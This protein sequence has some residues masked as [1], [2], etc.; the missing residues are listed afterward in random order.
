[1]EKKVETSNEEEDDDDEESD[2][3]VTENVSGDEFEPPS[4]NRAEK[5]IGKGSR[6]FAKW[7]DGHYYPGAV[8]NISGEK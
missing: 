3:Q 4:M 6:V 7:V 8:G 2:S 1:M 5:T